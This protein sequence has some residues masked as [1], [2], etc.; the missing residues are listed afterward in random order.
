MGSD[1]LGV[2]RPDAFDFFL[3]AQHHA[4]ALVQGL[5]VEVEDA[6]A[7][8]HERMREHRV[9]ARWGLFNRHAGRAEGYAVLQSTDGVSL[10]RLDTPLDPYKEPPPGAFFPGQ[11]W[12][13]TPLAGFADLR[14]ERTDVAFLVGEHHSIDLRGTTPSPESEPYR[15]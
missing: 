13:R 12:E 11:T 2:V 15:S 8:A 5:G 4:Y 7:A 10:L 1:P 14:R 9:D 6:V 3:R